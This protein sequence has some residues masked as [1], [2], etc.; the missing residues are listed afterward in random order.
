[1]VFCHL[2]HRFN[3][4]MVTLR[5]HTNKT[6]SRIT[7]RVFYIQVDLQEDS[8][9]QRDHYSSSLINCEYLL[10]LRDNT[11]EHHLSVLCSHWVRR[12]DHL[13]RC[14]LTTHSF[15]SSYS[16]TLF[17]WCS[18]K[19]LP[20]NNSSLLPSAHSI[21]GPLAIPFVIC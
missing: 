21:R 14:L 7:F 19:R 16:E 2:K 3:F 20:S 1:M 4:S 11:G 15:P 9:C 6:T 12:A 8:L 10:Q 5:E 18:F 17:K 13:T